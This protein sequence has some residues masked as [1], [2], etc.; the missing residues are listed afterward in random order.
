MEQAWITLVDIPR[1]FHEDR[2]TTMKCIVGGR[3]VRGE[4]GCR[5]PSPLQAGILRRGYTTSSSVTIFSRPLWGN[6]EPGL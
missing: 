5:I 4:P 2:K 1:L 6:R 3:R